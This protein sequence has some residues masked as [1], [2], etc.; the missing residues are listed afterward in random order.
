MSAIIAIIAIIALASG[1]VAQDRTLFD[2]RTGKATTRSTTD[3]Q[4]TITTFGADGK[5]IAREAT[6]PSGATTVYGADGRAIAR[7]TRE[8]R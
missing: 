3:S 8:K 2:A 6:T 4:G 7:T 1:A 5:V